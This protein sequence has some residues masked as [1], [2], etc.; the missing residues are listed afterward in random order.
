MTGKPMSCDLFAAV[1]AA[2]VLLGSMGM[3]LGAPPEARASET[4][5]GT[6]F[7]DLDRDGLRDSHEPGLPGVRVSDGRHVTTTDEEGRW[8]L[9]IADEAVL[10]VIKP[11]G[12]A[13]PVDGRKIPR[14]FYLHRPAG[15]PPGLRY[16]GIAPTGPL[17]ESIDFPLLRQE[18]PRRFSVLLFADTQPQ[19]SAELDFLRDDV[20]AELI[21]TPARFGMT[22]GDIAYDDL[23]LLPRL[24]SVVGQIGIPWYN[25]PGNHELNFLAVDDRHSLETY[26]R[27]FGPPYY[28][29]DY[30]EAHFVVLDNIVYEGFGEADPADYR[31]RGGYEPRI[32]E[33]QLAW[34]EQDL[35][36]VPKDRLVVLAMH[37]PMRTASSKKDTP[38]D[39][40]ASRRDL[41]KLLSGR[42]NL[43]AIAGHT[44]TTEHHY[45]G[46]ED[47]FEGPGELHHHVLATASGSWWSGPL[48]GRGIATAEQRDGTPN[49]WHVLEIDGARYTTRYRAAGHPAEFQMRI[50]ID[51]THHGY[52]PEAMRDVRPGAL[53]DGGISEDA[54]AAA[55]VVV[56]LF[57]GGPRSKVEMRI[58][59]GPSTPLARTPI[60]DPYV[61]ELFARHAGVVKPWVEAVPSTH[62][63]VAD[64][65]DGLEPGTHTL[66][67]EAIDEF[68]QRHVGHRIV[69]VHGSSAADADA[70]DYVR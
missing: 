17:P 60:F 52:R 8:S 25:V 31:P 41:F 13:P 20:V 57:D 69:E 24:A 36:F 10:F 23:S 58:G 4:A 16:P 64:L 46:P 55:R 21:G 48:D 66:T 40:R 49:G 56:N 67:V 34:L 45:F 18:E 50:S 9:E 35:A 15:S 12:F 61:R 1:R 39:N 47:G 27:N 43:Y 63:F 19:T 59:D 28:S 44:H 51:K 65:P 29:F 2:A 37:A 14:F 32:D 38:A 6:V 22:L 70:I 3:A 30:G 62:V 54:V 33:V 68:G 26:Q 5:R 11:A 53:L 7:E 42:E